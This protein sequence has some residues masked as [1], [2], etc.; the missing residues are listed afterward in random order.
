MFQTGFEIIDQGNSDITW[1]KAKPPANLR[2]PRI[3]RLKI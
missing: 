1:V 2:D 3:S